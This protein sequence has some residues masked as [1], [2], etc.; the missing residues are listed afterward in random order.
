MSKKVQNAE[1]Q[2]IESENEVLT[3]SEKIA[4]MAENQILTFKRAN[5]EAMEFDTLTGFW[6]TGDTTKKTNGKRSYKVT[7]GVQ[8]YSI[9][10]NA[11]VDV[12]D[13]FHTKAA[14]AIRPKEWDEIGDDGTRV[15]ELKRGF[16]ADLVGRVCTYK[17]EQTVCTAIRWDATNN[18]FFAIFANGKKCNPLAVEAGEYGDGWDAERVQKYLDAIKLPSL[19]EQIERL[20]TLREQ[21]EARLTDTALK[22]NALKAKSEKAQ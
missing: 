9:G 21:L 16:A 4:Q 17:G 1:N 7:N 3:L 22:I 15:N 11:I 18:T 2:Q 6:Y 14:N 10:E 5:P 20:E 8:T 12:L 13:A 19:K